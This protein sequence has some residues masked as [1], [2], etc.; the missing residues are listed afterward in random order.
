M[1]HAAHDNTPDLPEDNWISIAEAS[2]LLE[3]S[4]PT[5]RRW[6]DAGRVPSRKT[7][8]GHRRFSR[9]AI[10]AF[11]SGAAEM[12][13]LATIHPHVAAAAAPL[14]RRELLSQDWRQRVSAEPGVA[15]MREL[16]QRLLGLLLQHVHTRLNDDHYL[17]EAKSV[18]MT[19]GRE[20]ALAHIS[21][22][23]T[24]KAFV[25][26]RRA[27]ARLTAPAS[28]ETT[29]TTRA[30]LLEAVSLHERIDGFMDA[31]L[32]GVLGGFEGGAPEGRSVAP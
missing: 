2:R 12:A 6:S 7:L 13:A 23:D 1:I 30:D 3:V 17:A 14:D 4:A 29:E 27:C 8:G 28:A 9:S 16:G 26:F 20:A 10:E 5:L 15:R 19:Y 18:G 25:Y 32:L 31:V 21:L 22:S 11:A 24:V